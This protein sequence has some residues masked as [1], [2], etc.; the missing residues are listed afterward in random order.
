M[1]VAVFG[2]V[3][4][5]LLLLRALYR[6][7]ADQSCESVFV[8]GAQYLVKLERDFSL[9]AQH[10]MTFW[11]IAGARKCGIFQYKIVSK[12]GRL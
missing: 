1:A 11:E 2:E 8:A 10:V 5:R 6:G 12:I 4:G 7:E 9:Q 3:G